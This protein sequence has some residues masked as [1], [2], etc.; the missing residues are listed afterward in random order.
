MRLTGGEHEHG[1][2]DEIDKTRYVFRRFDGADAVH[3]PPLL[4]RCV[5]RRR[6]AVVDHQHNVVVVVRDVTL[7][8]RR[9]M[10]LPF[11]FS[12]I[13]LIHLPFRDLL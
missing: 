6:R 3:L 5:R 7:N 9:L 8:D 2:P 4:D 12:I 1:R 10:L 11:N 13:L